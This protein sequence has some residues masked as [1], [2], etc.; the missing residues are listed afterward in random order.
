MIYSWEQTLNRTKQI[1]LITIQFY[2][3]DITKTFLRIFNRGPVVGSRKWP[4]HWT[5]SMDTQRR[6]ISADAFACRGSDRLNVVRRRSWMFTETSKSSS[7]RRF[8]RSVRLLFSQCGFCELFQQFTRMTPWPERLINEKNIPLN[9]IFIINVIEFHSFVVWW[10]MLKENSNGI[11]RVD[12]WLP[13]TWLMVE[14][15]IKGNLWNRRAILIKLDDHFNCRKVMAFMIKCCFFFFTNIH[16]P[17][18]ECSN[19]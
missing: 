1:S 19:I 7:V 5:A 2:N 6:F 3:N 17:L 15:N 8:R 14:D 13:F 12:Y 11:V 4:L 16:T 9:D 18:R 10:R